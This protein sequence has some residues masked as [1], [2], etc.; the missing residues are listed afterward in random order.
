MQRIPDED[1]GPKWLRDYESIEAD[2]QGMKEF[3]AALQ[4]ELENSYLPHREQVNREMVVEG[5]RPDERFRELCHLLERHWFSRVMTT[6]LLT[7]HGNA[8]WTFA[9]TA[10]TVS[11]RHGDADGMARARA[12]D[13]QAYMEVPGISTP[14]A[15]GGA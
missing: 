11:D 2:L 6:A 12:E 15:T 13:I 10:Q 14:S 5:S 4:A 7:E 3:A 9:T 8:T 1:L